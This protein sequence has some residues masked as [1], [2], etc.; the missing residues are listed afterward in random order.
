MNMG[1]VENEWSAY[2]CYG[3]PT[4]SVLFEVNMATA[5]FLAE[6]SHLQ[7][8]RLLVRGKW[9]RSSAL[10]AFAT[11]LAPSRRHMDWTAKMGP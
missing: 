6:M 4:P 2:S 5:T 10:H 9:V 11:S 8:G 3:L 1:T 7:E